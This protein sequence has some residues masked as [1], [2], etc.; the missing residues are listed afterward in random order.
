MRRDTRCLYGGKCNQ[1]RVARVLV[2]APVALARSTGAPH[3]A[4]V[5]DPPRSQHPADRLI[6]DL[7]AT[8][9]DAS[10]DEVRVILDRIA[11]APFSRNLYKVPVEHRGQLFAG[12]ALGAREPSL[13]YHL[14]ERVALNGLWS[15]ET[16]EEDYAADLSRVARS[17][18]V[19]LAIYWRRGGPIGLVVAPTA[20]VVPV[21]RRGARAKLYTG[22]FYSVDWGT[23]VSGYQFDSLD[24]VSIPE[25]ARWLTRP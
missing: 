22:A 21:D 23:I 5:T 17:A 1:S 11:T 6:R 24:E 18:R 4:T 19:S 7:I 25:E 10:D 8:G 9:R 2:T 20:D 16:T 13:R 15:E 3:T 12:R 14:F